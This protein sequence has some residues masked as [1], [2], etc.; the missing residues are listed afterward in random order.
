[1]RL[2]VFLIGVVIGGALLGAA[3]GGSDSATSPSDTTVTP[4][5]ERFDATLTP[6]SSAFFSFTLTT[7]N[8]TVAINLASMSSLTAAGLIGV[9]MRIGYGVPAGTGCQV[10]QSII[11]A[12]ALI[13][14]LNVTLRDGTYCATVADIGNLTQPVNFTM[15]I[16]HQ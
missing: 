10:M 16:T 3:C 7:T 5:T 11:A 13:S 12:P 14:Q 15:R 6:G 2:R 9:P 8:G 1:M 4:T